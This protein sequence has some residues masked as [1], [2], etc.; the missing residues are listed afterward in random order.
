M[1]IIALGRYNFV[2]ASL[3]GIGPSYFAFS[4]QFLQGGLK[5]CQG[6]VELPPKLASIHLAAVVG[7]LPQYPIF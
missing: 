4:L 3:L 2:R 1:K 5:F 6:G 7:Q